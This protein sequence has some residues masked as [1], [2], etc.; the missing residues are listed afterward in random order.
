MLQSGMTDVSKRVGT[1]CPSCSPSIPTEHEVL[2][3]GGQYTVRCV[4]CDHVHKTSIDDRTITREVVVSQDGD[5][6]STSVEVPPEEPL[7]EGD[8]FVAESEMGVFTVRITSLELGEQQR[9]DAA[10]AEDVETIWTRDVG[11]V[12]V[13][14][15]IHPPEDAGGRDETRSVDLHVPGS[16]EFVVGETQSLAEEEFAIQGIHVLD[17]A[18]G[19]GFDKLDHD[20]DMAFAKDVKRVLGRDQG[21]ARHPWSPW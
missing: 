14:A 19:Y 3:E 8:E 18:D 6:F 10:T 16:H 1:T 17:D 20:G 15:T 9:T 5:S 21:M 2:S 7:E 13:P 11:N 12:T 4:E